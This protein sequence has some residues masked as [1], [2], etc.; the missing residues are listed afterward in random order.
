MAKLVESMDVTVIWLPEIEAVKVVL[1]ESDDALHLV[2]AT[3]GGRHA[4]AEGIGST[5][6]DHGRH[7]PTMPT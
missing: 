7:G 4:V 5:A 3:Q 2:E 1:V 6:E